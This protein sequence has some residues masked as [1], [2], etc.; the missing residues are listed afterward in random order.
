MKSAKNIE[1][2]GLQEPQITV[3]V[4]REKIDRLCKCEKILSDSDI[5]DFPDYSKFAKD[6]DEYVV[7][8]DACDVD[9][10]AQYQKLVKKLRLPDDPYTLMKIETI[11]PKCCTFGYRS[12]GIHMNMHIFSVLTRGRQVRNSLENYYQIHIQIFI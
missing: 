9:L 1:N 5:G 3:D 6:T 12:G 7:E 11:L 4:R 8:D 10:E 2:Q